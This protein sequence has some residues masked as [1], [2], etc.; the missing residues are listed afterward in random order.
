MIK[1]FLEF[2]N[3]SHENKEDFIKDLA[4]KL[5]QKIRGSRLEESPEYSSLSGISFSH[6]FAFELLIEL[7]KDSNFE[8]STDEHFKNL[9]WEDIN[10]QKNGYVIDANTHVHKKNSSIP[11]III[12]LVINPSEEPHL[13]NILHA[14][15]LD[16]LTH[17]LNHVDQFGINGDPFAEDS[18]HPKERKGAKKSYKYFLLQDEIESMV[19]GFYIRANHLKVPLDSIF[20]DYL[21]PFVESSYI[22]KEEFN[23]VM[24]VWVKYA[25]QR[26]PEATFSKKVEKIVNSI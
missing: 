20:N 9:P 23:K 13:Y 2:I 16:I 12:T 5:I 14:R 8:S 15:I 11:V 19:E 25:L 7:R 3:E 10:Y 6:P 24:E 26:Y 21:A 1:S 22:T 17:E 18:S 4:L